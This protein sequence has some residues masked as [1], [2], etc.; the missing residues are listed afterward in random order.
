MSK[1]WEVQAGMVPKT[2]WLR[3]EVGD[4]QDAKKENRALKLESTF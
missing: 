3:V 2:I 4:N 1:L